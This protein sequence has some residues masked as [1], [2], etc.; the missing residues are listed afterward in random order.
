M[1]KE[2]ADHVDD[3]SRSHP[4]LAAQVSGWHGLNA[5]MDWMQNRKPA[6][7]MDLIGQDEF[8]YDFLIPLESEGE[9]LV[10]GVT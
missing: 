8:E 6:G 3:L 7:P 5:V 1:P 10:L 9:W 4:A 2:Y